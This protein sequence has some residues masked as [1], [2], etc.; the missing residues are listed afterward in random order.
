MIRDRHLVT[1]EA[2]SVPSVRIIAGTARGRKLV[3]PPGQNTRP[4]TDRAKEGIFNMLASLGGVEDCVI[5]DLY[6]GS[7]SFGIECLSRGAASVTFV[8]QGRDAVAT[9]RKNLE[10]MGF[11]DRATI[12]PTSV[13]LAAPSLGRADVAFCDPPYK[14]AVWEELFLNVKADVLVGHAERTIEL[15]NGWSELRRREYGRAKILIAEPADM[16]AAVEPEPDEP[17]ESD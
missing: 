17:V 16:V 15:S 12:L 6:A 3:A 8:E 5:V 13:M 1:L 14:L 9:I 10:T 11:E 7:G 2:D 4:I